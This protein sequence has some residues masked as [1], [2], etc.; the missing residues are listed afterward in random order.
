MPTPWVAGRFSGA[1]AIV[2]SS[3][4]RTF[5]A[6]RLGT[7]TYSIGWTGANPAGFNYAILVSVRGNAT[8]SYGIPGPTA[9]E[10]YCYPLG[11]TGARMDLPQDASFMTIP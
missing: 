10:F 7:G 8:V 3:G 4:Q 5:T 1:P 11:S 6:S 2:S 9:F